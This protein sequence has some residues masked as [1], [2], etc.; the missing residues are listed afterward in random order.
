VTSRSDNRLPRDLA[1]WTGAILLAAVATT[2]AWAAGA[3]LGAALT[4]GVAVI[5]AVGLGSLIREAVSRRPAAPSAAPAP[6]PSAQTPTRA[7]AKRRKR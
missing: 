3:R 2:I 5:I 6:I 7:K 4:L 1:L